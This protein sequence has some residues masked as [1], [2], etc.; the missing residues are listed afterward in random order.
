MM[1]KDFG[2]G[3]TV[4]KCGREHSDEQ[5]RKTEIEELPLHCAIWNPKIH[6]RP[7]LDFHGIWETEIKNENGRSFCCF[8]FESDELVLKQTRKR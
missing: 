4:V 6:Q 5:E 8:R 7:D 3:R 1:I 2:F